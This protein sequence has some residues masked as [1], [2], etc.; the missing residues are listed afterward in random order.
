MARTRH[1]K[2]SIAATLLLATV[3]LVVGGCQSASPPAAEDGPIVVLGIDGAEWSVIR[4]MLERGEL[5]NL[6][7][8]IERGASGPLRSLDPRQGSPVIWTTI[9]TGKPPEEHGISGFVKEKGAAAEF[10][11]TPFSS[12]MWR[13]SAFWDVIGG[14]GR[15]VGIIGWLVTWPAWEVNGFMV[16]QYVQRLSGFTGEEAGGS[17]TFPAG[18]AERIAPLVR[19][20]GSVTAEEMAGFVNMESELGLRSLEGQNEEALRRAFSGDETAVTVALSLLADEMPDLSCVYIRG[21]DEVSHR[22]WVYMDPETRPPVDL[23]KPATVLLSRQTE[24]LVDL[25]RE[26][27]RYADANVGRILEIFPEDATVL[28]CSDH[29]FRG[30]GVW[31]EG[32][33]HM[34]IGQHSL[35]GVA[36]LAGPGIAPGVELQG[37]TVYDIAPTLLTMAGSAVAKDMPGRV[38]EEAFTTSFARSHRVRYVETHGAGPHGGDGDEPIES[39]VDDEVREQLRS[40]GYIE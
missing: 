21:I 16:S 14:A 3:L 33:P 36:I 15:E 9:A 27:Y 31:G 34:G 2:A 5:P 26:Y 30:P 28:V 18:L 1:V 13:A 40:L 24:A 20:S 8:L 4:P 23:S 29:G 38:L 12:N 37:A 7:S 39:P 11:N 19:E 22:F 17:V 10:H 6:A 32:R 35:D 25:V